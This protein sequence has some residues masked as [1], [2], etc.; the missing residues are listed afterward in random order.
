MFMKTPYYLRKRGLHISS[1]SI[2]ARHLA[3]LRHSRN[4]TKRRTDYICAPSAGSI[5]FKEFYPDGVRIMFALP[6]IASGFVGA[7]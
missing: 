7:R 6:R 3:M 4:A 5:L 2:K 1:V